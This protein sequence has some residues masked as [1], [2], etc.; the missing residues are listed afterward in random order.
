MV[1][2]Y[3]TLQKRKACE[4]FSVFFSAFYNFSSDNN[5]EDP[6]AKDLRAEARFIFVFKRSSYEFWKVA[7][8]LL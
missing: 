2:R 5:T 8:N 3:I 7:K 1:C 6:P 4:Y